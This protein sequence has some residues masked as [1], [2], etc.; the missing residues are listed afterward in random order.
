MRQYLNLLQYILDNGEVRKN[1]TGIDTI[2]VFGYQIKFDLLKGFPLVTT[3]KVHLKS[4]IYELLW[5]LSGSTNI[6]YLKQNNVTIWDEWADN[7]GNIGSAYGEQWRK[8]KDYNGQTIDQISNVIKDL[9]IN[10]FSRRHIVNA[11]N[12]AD[13]SKMKLPCCHFVYQFYVSNNNQLSCHMNMRSADALLG[14]PFNIASYAL[15]TMMIAQVCNY[16]VKEL[17]IS[18]GDLHIYLNHIEQ[19]KLQLT[20]KPRKLPTMLLNKQVDDIFLFDYKD[21]QL[22]GYDPYPAIKAEVAI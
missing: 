21:F 22:I 15:L 1:R 20:R 13:I 9:K 14:V 6:G 4:I 19:V 12:V 7:E 2:G 16:Q 17:I 8:W 5:L 3:K 11:W 10:P 18:F